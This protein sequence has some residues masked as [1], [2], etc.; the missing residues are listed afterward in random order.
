MGEHKLAFHIDS[1]TKQRLKAQA[2]WE[3]QSETEVAAEA[4]KVYLDHQADLRRSLD[5]A[6]AEADKGAFISSE[7]MMR[8]VKDLSLIHI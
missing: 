2:K 6:A 4:L 1:E 8:W 7:A 5:A 3:S